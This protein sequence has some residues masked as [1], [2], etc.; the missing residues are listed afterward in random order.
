MRFITL[1]F[2]SHDTQYS[3]IIASESVELQVSYKLQVDDFVLNY[4]Q[5]NSIKVELFESNNVKSVLIA[6]GFIPLASL[7]TKN[8][9][10]NISAVINDTVTLYNKNN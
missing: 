1:D 3:N 10:E 5:S 2:Y 4:F 7:V 8:V 9:H 6:T